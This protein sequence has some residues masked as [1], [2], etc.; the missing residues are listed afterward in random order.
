MEPQSGVSEP[1]IGAQLMDLYAI[2]RIHRDNDCD[3]AFSLAC[4]DFLASYSRSCH[5]SRA[6]S[7]AGWRVRTYG[8]LELA[9]AGTLKQA[10]LLTLS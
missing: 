8:G 10:Y 6:R 2:S 1:L 4:R 7:G 5:V 9:T 3:A